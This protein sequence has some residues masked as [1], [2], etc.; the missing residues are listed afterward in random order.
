MSHFWSSNTKKS[1]IEPKREFQAIGITDF[2]QPFLIQSMTKPS[3]QSISSQTVKKILKNG[4]IKTENHYKNDYQ[5]NSIDMTIIDAYDLEVQDNLLNSLNKSQTMFDLL[6]AGGWTLQSNERSRGILTA[7][8]ELLRFPNFQ[9]LELTPHARSSTKRKASAIASAVTDVVG[10]L[11]SGDFS[12][13]TAAETAST[14]VN[15]LGEN[16]AGVWTISRPV[17]TGV[18]FGDFNYNGDSITTIKVSL[19]YNNFKYEKSFV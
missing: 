7:T 12:L 6:T 10:D 9:I 5:L 18:N 2:V 4:T 19:A 1:Y 17:I 15:F 8:K 11:L 16:V 14:A 3:F 13:G